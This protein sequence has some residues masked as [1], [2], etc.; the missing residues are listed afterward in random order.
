MSI[1]NMEPHN[2]TLREACEVWLN[3]PDW[4]RFYEDIKNPMFLGTMSVSGDEEVRMSMYNALGLHR[5]KVTVS[6]EG[7]DKQQA[8]ALF[9]VAVHAYLFNPST[10][11]S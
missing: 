3:L 6:G 4:I 10:R 7:I 2:I 5:L 9:D 11:P 1:V 8:W